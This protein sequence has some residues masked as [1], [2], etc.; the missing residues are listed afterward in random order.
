MKLKNRERERER[1]REIQKYLPKHEV[2]ISKTIIKKTVE[3]NSQ[4]GVALCF[5]KN[6]N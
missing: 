2:K 1:E 4:I 6:Q 5:H 3:G